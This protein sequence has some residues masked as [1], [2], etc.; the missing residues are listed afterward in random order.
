MKFSK[1]LIIILILGLVIGLFYSYITTG[2]VPGAGVSTPVN[3]NY[4]GKRKKNCKK[5]L[6]KR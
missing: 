6:K 3:L 5:A 1:A 4:G 2:P